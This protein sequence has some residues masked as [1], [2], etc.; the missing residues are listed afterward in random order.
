MQHTRRI[1]TL[2]MALNPTFGKNKTELLQTIERFMDDS[3]KYRAIVSV[4]MVK[5]KCQLII[6]ND[7]NGFDIVNIDLPPILSK[8]HDVG[9]EIDTKLIVQLLHQQIIRNKVFIYNIPRASVAILNNGKDDIFFIPMAIYQKELMSLLGTIPTHTLSDDGIVADANE[10]VKDIVGT[11]DPAN[12]DLIKGKF[13]ST[14]AKVYHDHHVLCGITRHGSDFTLNFKD[15]GL[16]GYLYESKVSKDDLFMY[17]IKLFNLRGHH[18]GGMLNRFKTWGPEGFE[19]SKLY[20]FKSNKNI[21]Y[22][23]VSISGAVQ[24]STGLL[25]G[26]KVKKYINAFKTK[27]PNNIQYINL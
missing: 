11:V 13:K 5:D 9:N 19:D 22:A 1:A 24:T 2:S 12:P 15:K 25:L 27:L 16:E 23:V 18:I 17:L 20:V 26:N 10:L 8:W 6:H 4:K 7:N 14:D 21:L 3:P